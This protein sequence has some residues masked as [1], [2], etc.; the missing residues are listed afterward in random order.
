MTI[1]KNPDSAFK[2]I[3]FDS[4][5]ACMNHGLFGGKQDRALISGVLE[6]IIKG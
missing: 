2:F 5:H 6:K 3:V 4:M 1:T